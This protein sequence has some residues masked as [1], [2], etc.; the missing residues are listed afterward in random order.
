MKRFYIRAI[1]FHLLQKITFFCGIS[2]MITSCSA[3]NLPEYTQLGGMRILALVAD[4]PEVSPGSTVT[5][6]P[7][8]SDIAG[9]G[10]TLSYTAK[11][12]SDPG[13]AYGAE[14]NC[15]NAS[16]V[17][18]LAS[19]T[20]APASPRFTETAA[21]FSVVVPLTALALRG[22]REKYNGVAYLI[23]Y[24][25]SN[26]AGESVRSFRRVI[27]SSKSPKNQNPG[28]ITW[29]TTSTAAEMAALPAAEVTTSR[30]ISGVGSEAYS[31]I[32]GNGATQNLSETLTT[33][34]FTSDGT[35]SRYRTDGEDAINYAPPVTMPSSHAT[36][37]VLVVRDDRGG[38]SV[39][40]YGF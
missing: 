14:P 19:G 36:V 8:I 24:T 5:I 9:A 21:S 37:V 33:T 27:V 7:V 4:A 2:L 40:I 29:L 38:S 32:D 22:D 30:L 17:Q 34:W 1:N 31:Y 6:T 28:T 12:C 39:K 18:S 20:F 16:D 23:T 11:A 13:V 15:E 25:L 35:F 3:K 10:R 26:A